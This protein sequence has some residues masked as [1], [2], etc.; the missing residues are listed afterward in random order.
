MS[1]DESAAGQA[2]YSAFFFYD[3]IFNDEIG[4]ERCDKLSG[5]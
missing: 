3:D 5:L 1:G 2:G 4:D